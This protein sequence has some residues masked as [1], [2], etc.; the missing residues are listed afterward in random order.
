MNEKE[1]RVIHKNLKI[2]K[3]KRVNASIARNKL[4]GIFYN[5]K[6]EIAIFSDDDTYINNK[7][8]IADE[9]DCISL[10][11]DYKKEQKITEKINSSFLIINNFKIKY[12]LELYFDENLEAN[13]DLDFGIQ[14]NN[15]NI[16]T[17]RQ[18]S[19]DIVIYR[20]KSSM[21]S[22]NMNRINK[23]QKSL[24]YIKKKYGYDN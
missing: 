19:E 11:N 12:Q 20:G 17:L 8:L 15:F 6:E 14:L 16:K 9:I 3:G 4:L 21:F 1:V 10:T 24:D 5:S 23:K 22:S 7:I 18:S 2:I 13:Q